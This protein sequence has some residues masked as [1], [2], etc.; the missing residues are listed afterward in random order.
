MR[1]SLKF[2]LA[3]AALLF[4]MIFACKKNSVGNKP[5]GSESFIKK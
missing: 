2:A 4:V 1:T 3:L 5:A